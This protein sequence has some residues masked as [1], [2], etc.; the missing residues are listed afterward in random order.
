MRVAVLFGGVSEERDVS[1]VSGAQV[2]AALRRRGHDTWAVDTARGSLSSS[3]CEQ[4]LDTGVAPVPPGSAAADVGSVLFGL[5]DELRQ[6]DVVF[7]AL[8][9][10]SGED[11]TVQALLDLIGVPYTGSG[12]LGSACAMDKDISKRLFR[13]A[14]VPTAD[15]L[16]WPVEPERVSRELGY[17][18]VV[19]PNRQG[20]TVGLSIVR[21]P[22]ELGAAI[23][24]ARRFDAEVM[25]ERFVPGRELTV[26]ILADAPL[27]VG[28]IRPKLHEIFDYASK[29]QQGGAEEIFPAEITD[30]LE[31]SAK[32]YALAAHR[33]LKLGPYSRADFR[34]DPSGQL[35]CLEVNTV[36]GMTRTSLLPQSADAVGIDFDTLCERICLLALS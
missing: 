25:L 15:W 10:G 9:G 12:Q 1:V 21:D 14:G 19:K 8:H 36:P 29:Y 24:L 33:A 11:G 26:G 6:V 35:Y 16:M 13:A 32:A 27:T 31:R 2:V 5:R 3:E 34:L 17:P 23:E 20:S 30:E 22:S 4:L 18:L 28:E 7:V